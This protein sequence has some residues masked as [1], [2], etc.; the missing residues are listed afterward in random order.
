M[1]Y[2]KVDDESFPLEEELDEGDPGLEL[3]QCLHQFE[4]VD[5]VDWIVGLIPVEVECI[6]V[7]IHGDEAVLL[8]DLA[9]DV[10]E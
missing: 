3:P 5:H 8:R 6:A 9:V 7:W 10:V 1:L 4:D 2:L